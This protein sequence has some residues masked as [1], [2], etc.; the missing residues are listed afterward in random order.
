VAFGFSRMPAVHVREA[1]PHDSGADR[2]G[3]RH[4][5]AA[6]AAFGGRRGIRLQPDVAVVTVVAFGFSRMWPP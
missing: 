5:V 2:S 4:N 1:P 6:V 3:L